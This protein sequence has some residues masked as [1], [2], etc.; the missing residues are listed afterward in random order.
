MTYDQSKALGIGH[1]HP[2]ASGQTD[3][4]VLRRL[5]VED[6]VPP[7]SKEPGD[8]MNKTERAF[9][10]M[11]NQNLSSRQYQ[12]AREPLKLRLAGRT[13]YT[14]DFG[15]WYL[16]NVEASLGNL[17]LVEVKGFMRDDASVKIKVAANL[18]PMWRFL[19]VR[20]EGRHGWNVREVGRTGI[21]THPI[22]VPWISGGGA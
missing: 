16:F 1:L 2:A 3:A 14:P 22:V 11:L 10:E 5:G 19:L 6:V 20:R 9:A 17:T 7:Q 12:W 15:V 4:E 13:W 8:G 21:G 18:Y